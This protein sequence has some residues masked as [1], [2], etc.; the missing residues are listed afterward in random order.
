MRYSETKNAVK[1]F[2]LETPALFVWL[3]ETDRRFGEDQ[4]YI[5]LCWSKLSH[6]HLA[7]SSSQG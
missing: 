1:G 2:D 3:E 6:Y 7:I 4:S 5:C